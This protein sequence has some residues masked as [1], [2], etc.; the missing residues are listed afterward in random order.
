MML[1]NIGWTLAMKSHNGFSLLFSDY[2]WLF[3][4]TDCILVLF[5]QVKGSL[6]QIRGNLDICLVGP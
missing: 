3:K 2:A 6:Y 1:A 4:Y 5:T